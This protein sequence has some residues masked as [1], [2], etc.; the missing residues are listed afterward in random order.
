MFP[1]VVVGFVRDRVML[2]G[3]PC[4]VVKVSISKTGKRVTLRLT[5]PESTCSPE[6]VCRDLSHV[7]NMTS[8]VMFRDSGC[9]PIF[10]CPEV[11]DVD[12]SGWSDWGS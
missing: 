9:L 5:L 3:H 10:R 1:F 7:H 2:K 4:K 6:E 8:P 12:E 11:D